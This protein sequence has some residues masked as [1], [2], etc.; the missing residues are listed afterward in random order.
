LIFKK[1]EDYMFWLNQLAFLMPNYKNI[2]KY[3]S[4]LYFR[5]ELPVFTSKKYTYIVR[6]RMCEKYELEVYKKLRMTIDGK[7]NSMS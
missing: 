6:C 3:V 7:Q 1:T 5:F 4:Q 2:K